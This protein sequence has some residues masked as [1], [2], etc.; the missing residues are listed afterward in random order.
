MTGTLQVYLFGKFEARYNEQI[1]ANFDVR[2]VQELLSYLLLYR[3]RPHPRE[4]LADLLWGD[5]VT[6]QSKGYLRKAL[7]QLQTGMETQPKPGNGKFLLIEPDW[8]QLNPEANLWL[9]VAVFEQTFTLVQ[10]VS[11]QALDDQSAQ[12]VQ[13]AI[14]LYRG[15]LLEGWYSDWCLYERERLQHTFLALLDK[16]MNYHKSKQEYEIAIT[17]GKRSLNYDCARERTHRQ[18]MQLYYLAGDRTAALRQYECCVATLHKELAVMPAQRTVT[19]YEQ[20]RADQLESPVAPLV[21]TKL[22]LDVTAAPLTE[23]LD[24]LRQF[25]DSL[26]NLQRQLQ[27]GIQA[28]EMI[29]N[30][31]Y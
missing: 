8:V 13:R 5:C 29:I 9:D 26:P 3:D 1:P 6:T 24:R 27:H 18:L 28:I 16:L 31:R 25:H 15:D 20:I 23:V 7:W 21:Q 11:G 19:I 12:L 14:K 17:Y 10:G 4:T 22:A 2:K 30:D